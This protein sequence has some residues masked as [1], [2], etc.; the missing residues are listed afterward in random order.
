MTSG[1]AW[2]SSSCGKRNVDPVCQLSSFDFRY[3]YIREGDVFSNVSD[4]NLDQQPHIRLP[5]REVA[6]LD[7]THL[8]FSDSLRHKCSRVDVPNANADHLQ[9]DNLVR[10]LSTFTVAGYHSVDPV[11]PIPHPKMKYI[12]LSRS[13]YPGREVSNDSRILG[14]HNSQGS[15]GEEYER[16]ENEV[17]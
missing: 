1:G 4:S 11:T 10:T 14:K 9:C 13:S 12:A 8:C 17:G 3:L 16:T 2:S 15:M 7:P 5:R 6:A